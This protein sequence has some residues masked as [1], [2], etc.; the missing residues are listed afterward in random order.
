MQIYCLVLCAAKG[1]L[2]GVKTHLCLLIETIQ[3][4]LHKRVGVGGSQKFPKNIRLPFIFYLFVIQ[5]WKGYKS[6]G[7]EISCKRKMV[8]CVPCFCYR[9]VATESK[10]KMRTLAE[11]ALHGICRRDVFW[12]NWNESMQVMH[13]FAEQTSCEKL[14]CFIWVWVWYCKFYEYIESHTQA[15]ARHALMT[16]TTW[17]I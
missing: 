2:N 3:L 14:M 10:K 15:D 4:V 1:I 7:K 12:W 5:E 13:F 8:W 6:H 11:V 17:V 9:N 16:R